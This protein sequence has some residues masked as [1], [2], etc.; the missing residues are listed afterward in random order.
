M[1]AN[2]DLGTAIVSSEH[3]DHPL[4]ISLPASA[5]V[6]AHARPTDDEV[7]TDSLVS[8]AAAEWFPGE[9]RLTAGLE[10]AERARLLAAARSVLRS[11][12]ASA[13]LD[14][15]LSR[16]VVF[17]GSDAAWRG[18]E[19]RVSRSV[20]APAGHLATIV[21]AWFCSERIQVWRT[22]RSWSYQ[23]AAH[24]RSEVI[25]AALRRGSSDADSAVAEMYR[26]LTSGDRA[27]APFVGCRPCATV[28]RYGLLIGQRTVEEVIE[29]LRSATSGRPPHTNLA[30]HMASQASRAVAAL[31]GAD[32]RQQLG[33]SLCIAAHIGSRLGLSP[34]AQVRLTATVSQALVDRPGAETVVEVPVGRV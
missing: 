9:A 32:G 10:A 22:A 26:S 21:F 16:M 18:L 8:G 17:G 33:A 13:L 14:Q 3:D 31:G 6:S 28:C 24:L 30:A 23:A 11:H 5:R 1:I 29:G 4:L 12:D 20:G 25:N 19:G 34:A 27:S 2:L 15:L 7:A